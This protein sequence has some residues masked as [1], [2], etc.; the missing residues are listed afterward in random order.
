M[1]LCYRSWR[2]PFTVTSCSVCLDDNIWMAVL[3]SMSR[4]SPFFSMSST[5]DGSRS[6][7]YPY[8]LNITCKWVANE[9]ARRDANGKRLNSH[10]T[11]ITPVL[12]MICHPVA[13]TWYRLYC[14]QHLTTLGL[15]VP[16]IWLKPQKFCNGSHDL[17]TPLYQKRFV[18][19]RLLLVHSTGCHVR[20]RSGSI[21]ETVQGREIVTTDH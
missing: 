7:S 13:R 10:V 18:V 12:C 5:W 1:L 8:A 2:S 21:S 6:L 15:A 11:I 16:V 9:T 3:I 19:C 20:Y 17:T 14:V 4:S